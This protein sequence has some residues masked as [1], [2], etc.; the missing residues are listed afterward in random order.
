[1]PTRLVHT[2]WHQVTIRLTLRPTST[3]RLIKVILRL[4]STLRLTHIPIKHTHRTLRDTTQLHTTLVQHTLT[5]L[6]APL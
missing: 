2:L 4:P 3:H 5:Q 6:Q 1:M